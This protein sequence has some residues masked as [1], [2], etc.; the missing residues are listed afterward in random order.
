MPQLHAPKI[1]FLFV[2][3]M[4]RG[5]G[6]RGSERTGLGR[7]REFLDRLLGRGMGGGCD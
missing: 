4:F 1:I 5:D 2:L 3:I 7:H 6:D